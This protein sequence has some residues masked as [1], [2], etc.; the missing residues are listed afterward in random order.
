M[1]RVSHQGMS[2]S[3]SQRRRLELERAMRPGNYA[4]PDWPAL[5]ERFPV[6]VGPPA[7]RP[8]LTA[9]QDDSAYWSMVDSFEK[10]GRLVTEES[11]T[12]APFCGD[13]STTQEEN[14]Q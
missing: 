10:Y 6:L 12:G 13:R 2:L 1:K 5:R 14:P 7:P 8:K 3:A 11:F 9:Q 4:E